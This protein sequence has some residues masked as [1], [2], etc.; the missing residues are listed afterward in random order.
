MPAG[1]VPWHSD[2]LC[3]TH[4]GSVS[5]LVD[6]MVRYKWGQ[7][8]PGNSSTPRL[9]GKKRTCHWENLFSWRS[10]FWPFL[11]VKYA[12]WIRCVCGDTAW[13]VGWVR[14][15]LFPRCMWDSA[16]SK[17][18]ISGSGESWELSFL[19]SQTGPEP[20]SCKKQR[21]S[22]S[23]TEKGSQGPTDRHICLP[24]GYPLECGLSAG[25]H[26]AKPGWEVSQQRPP[27][28][29]QPFSP[30]W[31]PRTLWELP[32]TMPMHIPALL[33]ENM[34]SFLAGQLNQSLHRKTCVPHV[35]NPRLAY[36]VN[37]E[38]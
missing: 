33:A 28:A 7:P 38:Y 5:G 26:S 16:N 1:P 34:G 12:G 30:H 20:P 14:S 27:P 35:I 32:C 13:G 24:L 6:E 25:K 36:R 21:E 10:S 9:W 2:L 4:F 31:A 3:S 22:K 23:I 29:A 17:R 15:S 19:D 37:T 18:I 11:A 8:E